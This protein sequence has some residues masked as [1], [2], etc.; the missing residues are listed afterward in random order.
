MVLT[1]TGSRPLYYSDVVR[2]FA[3]TIYLFCF[4]FIIYHADELDHRYTFI[5]EVVEPEIPKDP[6]VEYFE[7][8]INDLK[9]KLKTSEEEKMNLELK[10][11]DVINE[12]EIKMEATRLDNEMKMEALAWLMRTK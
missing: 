8:E 4:V 1:S 11:A 12:N 7:K 5:Q 9:E 3:I 2:L 10:F 6:I